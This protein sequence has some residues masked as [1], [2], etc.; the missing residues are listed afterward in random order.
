MVNKLSWLALAVMLSATLCPAQEPPVAGQT[1]PGAPVSAADLTVPQLLSAAQ[2][3]RAARRP[4]EAIN[5]L[6]AILQRDENNIDAL[7]L[8]GD[9]AWEGQN[10]ELARNSWLRVR[11]IQPNDFGA[12]FGL[13][14]L[15]MASGSARSAVRYLEVAASVVP[16]TRIAEVFTLLAQAY[17]GTNLRSQALEAVQKALAADSESFEAWRLLV[18]LRTNAALTEE[19]LDQAL[20]DAQRLKQL[21]ADELRKGTTLE[22]L[23]RLQM[24]YQMELQV[25]RAFGRVIFKPNPDGRSYSDQVL[26]GQERLAAAT[27]SRTAD[28]MLRQAELNHRL[29]RF[30]IIQFAAKAVQYDRGTNPETL[31]VLGL[32]QKE[33]GQLDRAAA[34]FQKVLELDPGNP[35]AQRQLEELRLSR[36]TVPAATQPAPVT[37]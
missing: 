29:S 27:F 11:E 9:V 15:H 2:Q 37:P 16:A 12:N 36:P 32:L 3:Y 28:V 14:R 24:A 4:N 25:L 5:V 33:T 22:R 8:L 6:N 19:E 30:Q 7:R 13:G 31:M 34:T 35:S 10:A 18:A 17:Y 21:A 1:E 23:Q 20:T 26:E